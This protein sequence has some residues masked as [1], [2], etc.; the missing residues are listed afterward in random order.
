MVIEDRHIHLKNVYFYGERTLDSDLDR[1]SYIFIYTSI[2]T[3]AHTHIDHEV[4]RDYV[5]INFFF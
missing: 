5:I 1:I 3:H 2:D 4:L